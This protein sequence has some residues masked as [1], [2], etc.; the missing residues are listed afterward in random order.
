MMGKTQ[1]L[2]FRVDDELK[3]LI[4]SAAMISG[5]SVSAFAVS[6]LY[7]RAKQVV[8]EHEDLKLSRRD[9]E[10]FLEILDSDVEPTDALKRAFKKHRDTYE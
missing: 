8:R 4:E 3:S 9:A 10:R 6:A 5:E 1:R 7:E 2:D